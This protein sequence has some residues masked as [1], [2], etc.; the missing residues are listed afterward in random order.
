MTWQE[1]WYE[2]FGLDPPDR[3]SR[4]V[5]VQETLA[6][7]IT[8]RKAAWFV[9]YVPTDEGATFLRALWVKAFGDAPSEPFDWFVS[10]YELP[11]PVKWRD[12]IGLTYG[13]PDVA[14]RSADRILI[15]ELKTEAGSYRRRQMPDYLRLARCKHPTESLDLALLGPGRPP[16]A[17]ACDDRQRYAELT[18]SE[19]PVLLS[20]CFPGDVVASG[21]ARFLT[22]GL[23]LRSRP[24][25]PAPSLAQFGSHVTSPPAGGGNNAR[26][27]A[28]IEHALQLAPSVAGARPDDSTERGIDV[29]FAF[30]SD[31][32]AA[33]LAVKQA[34]ADHGFARR[35]TVW[36]WRRESTGKPATPAGAKEGRELRLA[37]VRS[38]TR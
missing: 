14:C 37:P 25:R 17:P 31:A 24:E 26:V 16:D 20:E 18:W 10:E 11:V 15:V 4:E 1:F 19:V 33:R 30:D 23:A 34:L 8:G 29:A 6:F 28:A 38:M 3:T 5:S 7:L 35:V 36:L 32:Q 22:D 9:Q 13:C 12:E 2:I 27:A 21:L